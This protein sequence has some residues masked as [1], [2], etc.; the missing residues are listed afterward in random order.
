MNGFGGS[1]WP[2][3][4]VI[5]TREGW[6]E[7]DLVAR[8]AEVRAATLTKGKHHTGN[9]FGLSLGAAAT[10]WP[11]PMAGRPAQNGNSAA[12]NSDFSRKAEELALAMWTTPQAH[13]VRMRGAGQTSG[14]TGTNA[15]NRCLATDAAMRQT[16]VSDDRIDRAKGKINSRGEPK[17]SGQAVLWGTP[18]ASDAEK[19]GPNMA[20]GAGGTPLPA[21]A[22]HWQATAAQN[23]KGSSPDSV[24]RADGKSRMDILHYL[25]EQGFTHPAPET[26]THGLPSSDPRQT[27]RRLRRL[28]ISTHGR[29]TWKRMAASGGK[30]RL[31][32]LFVEWL[33]GWP[34]G[35]ALCDCSETEWSRFQRH[36]RG[37]LSRLPMA[38]GPWIWKPP[39]ERT[40]PEQMALW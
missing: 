27:W 6:S 18:R 19:G 12:G 39:A 10:A 20:F 13:D 14:A 36:M 38:S 15:G 40:E 4:T 3:A 33:M 28:V 34:P 2:T 5:S 1:A 8:Q 32:P 26:Q 24:T 37:A 29:A 21:Q 31:N 7:E 25:A 23:V 22:A 9:G 11:T 35:H 16:P 17:L 30:R